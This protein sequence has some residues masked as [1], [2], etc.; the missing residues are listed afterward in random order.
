MLQHYLADSANPEWIRAMLAMET[1]P[2]PPV[3]ADAQPVE[4]QEAA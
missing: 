4:L 1:E 3:P 2:E